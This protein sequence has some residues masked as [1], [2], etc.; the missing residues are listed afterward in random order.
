M[1]NSAQMGKILFN[2]LWPV[3]LYLFMAI[4]TLHMQS[5]LLLS[6]HIELLILMWVFFSCGMHFIINERNNLN[7]KNPVIVAALI[8]LVF[9]IS[10]VI[11]SLANQ[12]FLA[13]LKDDEYL[14]LFKMI[15]FSPCLF[16]V[17]KNE[18]NQKIL[19]NSI[20]FFYS[21]FALYF[22]YRYLVLHE[23]RSF[24][25]RPSLKIR[26][27]D[28]NFLATFFTMIIPLALMQAWGSVKENKSRWITALFVL[29][30]L[31]ILICA[32]LTQSRMGIIALAVGIIYLLSKPVINISKTKLA[33]VAVSL[34]SIAVIYNGERLFARFGDLGDKSNTDRYLTFENGIKL[35]SENPV[36]GAGAHNAKNYFFQNTGYPHFQSEF[37]PLEV[38]NTFLKIAAELGITGLVCFS[39]LFFWPWKKSL[40][41]KSPERF[42]LLSSLITLT[43]SLMTIGIVYKDLFIIHLFFVAALAIYKPKDR[44]LAQE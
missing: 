35:F 19:L 30:S 25:L 43:L 36:F 40:E 15:L 9:I 23:V 41:L 34:I 31:L 8:G 7:Y 44:A 14:S 28:A 26:H 29:A 1:K 12:D 4:T 42:F 11:T 27:G 37:K 33:I 6:I 39:F 13:I 38:H 18:K 10:P 32:L 20:I 22:L 16:L 5:S 24:D 2:P 21:I 17:M 3:L